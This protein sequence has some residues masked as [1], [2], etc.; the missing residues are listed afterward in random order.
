MELYISKS[1]GHPIQL[2]SSDVSEYS[3]TIRIKYKVLPTKQVKSL[4]KS[5][6]ERKFNIANAIEI[7]DIKQFYGNALEN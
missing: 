2:L 6:F 7:Q 4:E 3:S 1:N 5:E